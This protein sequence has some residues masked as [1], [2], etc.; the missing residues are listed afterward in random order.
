MEPFYGILGLL[1]FP[2]VLL[3]ASFLTA[4]VKRVRPGMYCMLIGLLILLPG[5]SIS[6]SLGYPNLNYFLLG[7]GV[8]DT[9]LGLLLILMGK[10]GIFLRYF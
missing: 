1:A 3:F 2:A 7:N 8:A 9:F 5:L 4:Y 6:S 10:D